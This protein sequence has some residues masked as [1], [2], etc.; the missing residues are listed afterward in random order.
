LTT[1]RKP[2]SILLESKRK[3]WPFAAINRESIG[4]RIRKSG[5]VKR[6]DIFIE[7]IGAAGSVRAAKTLFD[8]G[9]RFNANTKRWVKTK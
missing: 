1:S 4:E 3:S 2:P 6:S 8:E 9:Y 7:A 5:R